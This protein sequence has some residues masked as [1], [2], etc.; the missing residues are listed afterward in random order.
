MTKEE[1][2]ALGL[3]EEQ[4]AEIFKLNGIAVNA[5]KGDLDTK[6]KEVETLQG[7]L[8]TANKEIEDFKGLNVDEIQKKADDYK[9]DFEALEIKAKEELAKV[10]FEHE[11][12]GMARDLKAKN[13]KAVLALVEDKETLLKSNNRK[14]DMKKVFETIA[15]DNEFLFGEDMK[16]DGTGGSMGAG[17]KSKLAI[18]KEQ[19]NAL[20]YRERVELYNKQPELYNTLNQD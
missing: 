13:L 15:A 19:F 3:T 16:A 14:E 12:E 18:T 2:L 7:Q 9:K 6:V 5:A 8:A 4:I 20:G 11:L 1:L 10:Q 17:S